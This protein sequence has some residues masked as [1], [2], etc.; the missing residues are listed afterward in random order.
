MPSLYLL[1]S[2]VKNIGKE[3][4][5]YFSV[6]LSEVFCEAYAQVHP[7]MHSSMRHLFGTWSAVFPLS[8][9]RKIETLLQ[10]SP[11]LHGQS[12]GLSSSRVSESP[13][14]THG[15]HV[16]PKYL[17]AQ[18][19]LHS[20]VDMVGVEGVSCTGRAG[21]TT[22]GLGALKRPLTSAVTIAKSASPYSIGH[23]GS[24]S[25]SLE[26]FGA[27]NSPR[28]LAVR[29]SPSHAGIDY[30]LSRVMDIE[31][32]TNFNQ[33]LKTSS[34][35]N[36]SNSID[37]RGTRA[38]INAYGIDER[39]KNLKPIHQIGGHL[40][41]NSVNQK[42]ARIWQ[43][44]EE[45]EFDWKDMTSALSD[46]S[47][48]LSYNQYPGN[49]TA[50]QRF[51]ANYGDTLVSD[52]GGNRSKSVRGSI[53][54]I[55]GD[56]PTIVGTSE[57][58]ILQPQQS[59][60]HLNAKG[61]G[62]FSESRSSFTA[63]EQKPP[64]IGHF[65]HTNQKFGGPSNA[66]STFNSTYD[67]PAPEFRSA[68]AEALAK[69][70]HPAKLPNSH[71]F[72][73]VSAPP[74]MQIRG[75][76]GMGNAGTITT[77]Q[78]LNKRFHSEHYFSCPMSMAQVYLPQIPSQR[79]GSILL[80]RRSP[81]QD[82][83]VQPTFLMPQE[84]RQNIPPPC[85]ASAPSHAMVPPP[86]HGYYAQGHGPRMQP[87]LPN[88]NT[89]NIS[90]HIPGTGFPSQIRGPF[91]GKTPAFPIGQNI[92]Q[93]A[94]N[95][96][97]GGALPGL[98]DSLVSQGLV[99]LTKQDSVVLEFD[100]ESLKVHNESA[101]SAL[102]ADLP[103]QCTS[104]GL[105]FKSQ[106][107][108]SKHMDWHVNKNRTLK[109]RKTK[110]SPKWFVTVTM[111]LS[112]AEALGT[113][114]VPGFLPAENNVEKEEDEEMAVPADEDQNACS[115]C[116]EPFE[117]FYSDDTEEWMYKGATYMYAPPVLTVGMDRSKLGPIVHAKCRSDSHGIPSEDFTKEKG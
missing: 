43:N 69:E 107:E 78:G 94:S 80:N 86:S 74:Q 58:I 36:F 23:G 88:I 81:A 15:I 6:R 29:A 96:Q 114:A 116:G 51:T 103:R 28:R 53:D 21:F 108:H 73:L 38:L 61:G 40:E 76:F 85:S 63:S 54:K 18:H 82:S 33:H 115:L 60:S 91:P 97:A 14:P 44:T 112:G 52:Y 104:C 5:N 45:E 102:Y 84:V 7:S 70:W 42:V 19:Q 9:L 3:Y 62:F 12:S 110:P 79:P 41:G 4:I 66:M 13:R 11:S 57:S 17:G 2:I 71:N 95:P 56:M 26:E 55:T 16:N 48:I 30:R 34:A 77:D 20:S 47:E 39:E 65:P 106:D 111:W 35:Y 117:D 89:R 59:K 109:N 87:P 1:D 105:R 22:S 83:L 101:I 113:E 8:V 98:V 68:N 31:E 27:H 49:S 90:Y 25:P 75:H 32:E 24:L 64:V 50:R 72:P 10:F 67:S 93:V 46:R 99:S 37:L 92:G 100:Q